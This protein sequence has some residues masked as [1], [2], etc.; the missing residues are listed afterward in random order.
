MDIN[1]FVKVRPHL[2]HLTD[3]KNLDSILEKQEILST[4]KLVEISD[5]KN[6]SQFLTTRRVTHEEILAGK[7]KYYIRDQ[8]PLSLKIL[9]GCLEDGCSAEDFIRYLNSKVFFWGRMSGLQSHYGRYAA[10]NEKPVILRVETQEIFN[11]NAPP[12]FTHLNSGAPR[13]S[14]YL[15]GKGSP[16]GLD[17]FKLAENFEQS[18]SAVN[19]VVFDHSC[20]LPKQIYIG[21]KPEGPFKKIS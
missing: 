2:Y 13:C 3:E 12:R 11:L 4:V 1:K 20:T 15:G 9:A 16:R 6:K 14:A 18:A 10:E 17:T 19:E 21:Y 8:Y 5:L 7:K